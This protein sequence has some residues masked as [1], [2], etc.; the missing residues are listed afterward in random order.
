M[1]TNSPPVEVWIERKHWLLC[2][3]YPWV[4]IVHQ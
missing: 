1:S 3:W 4:Q 2:G